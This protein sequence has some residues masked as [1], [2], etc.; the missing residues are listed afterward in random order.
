MQIYTSLEELNISD[1]TSVAL[2]NFDG[3]HVGHRQIMED[4][5]RAADEKGLKSLCFT[6]SNHP[7]NFILR[8]SDDDPD[9]VKLICTEEEKISLVEDMGFDILVNIPFDETIMKMRA[10]AFF[11]DIVAGKLN[12]GCISVGFNYTYGARAEGKPEDLIEECLTAGID[13]NIHEAVRI[14]GEI[15]SSTLIRKMISEGN[16]EMTAEYLGRPYTFSGTVSHGRHLGSSKG[17]PTINFPA[18]ARQML[19]PN[20]VY[21]SRTTVGGRE[22]FSVSNIGMKPTVGSEIKTIETNIFDFD[23]DI[24]GADVEVIFDHF[25]RAEV[26]FPNKEALFGQIARDCQNAREYYG[27]D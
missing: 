12:A 1:K 6:F 26:N 27:L 10:H 17:F 20:G 9:A 22:Y 25:S 8:R 16:M 19:P 11:T 14:K 18:P 21:F 2:G 13:A 4:A 5:L 15:V 24:Y 7:F 23:S 3:L